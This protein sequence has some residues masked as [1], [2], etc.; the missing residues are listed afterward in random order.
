MP[1]PYKYTLL[2]KNLIVNLS[3]LSFKNMVNDKRV[4]CI[5]FW[6]KF[7][8]GIR[9]SNFTYDEFEDLGVMCLRE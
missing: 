7:Y 4:I 1:N 6:D 8:E 3:Y 9:F 5:Y 2:N